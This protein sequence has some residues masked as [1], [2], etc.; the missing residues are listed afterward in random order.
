M[1]IFLT[2]ILGL[3]ALVSLCLA[4]LSLLA[5]ALCVVEGEL[6]DALITL[7]FFIVFTA[8]FVTGAYNC[9][10]LNHPAPTP[11]CRCAELFLAGVKNGVGVTL[12][13]YTNTL[14]EAGIVMIPT[15]GRDE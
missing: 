6:R 11:K 8:A 3:L 10:N 4:G 5:M 15:G 1:D 14:H 12:E 2:V 13:A 9:S 7:A